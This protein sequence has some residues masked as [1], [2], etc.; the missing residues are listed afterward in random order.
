MTL[1]TPE[2]AETYAEKFGE[3]PTNRL[4]VDALS[5]ASDEVVLDVGCGTAAALRHASSRVTDGRLVGVD[6]IPRMR[7][8]AR[9]RL[10]GHAAE[11]RIEILAGAADDLPLDDGS[12]DVV[13]AF[14]SYDHWPDAD[15][16]LREI[17]RVLRADG[18]LAIVKDR[19][20]P[21]TRSDQLGLSLERAGFVLL[22]E[23]ERGGEGVR[24][25]FW[26]C[27]RADGP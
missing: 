1:W 15:A 25:R 5:L 13:L 21:G 11:D 8:I 22:R 19:G 2:T 7:E 9:E 10:R 3:Y 23:E 4:A 12:A 16:G 26:E 17:H 24:F 14:D 20:I 18:R 27:R 6:P